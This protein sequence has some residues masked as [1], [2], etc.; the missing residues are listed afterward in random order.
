MRPTIQSLLLG[1]LTICLIWMGSA[2]LYPQQKNSFRLEELVAL[3]LE[4]N[5]Q[6]SAS[7]QNTVAREAAFQ[8]SR[9]LFNPELEFW[10]GQAE[11]YD[12]M[13]ER[14]TF[15]LSVTQPLENPFKRRYRVQMKKEA[16][17]EALHGHAFQVQEVAFRIKFQYFELLLLKE[18]QALL[19]EIERSIRETHQLIAKRAELGEV[20]ELEAIKLYV[21]TLKVQKALTALRSEQELAHEKLNNLV[22]N[23]LPPDYQVSGAL[24]FQT[25]ELDEAALLAR[26]LSLHPLINAKKKQLAQSL[27]NTLYVKWQRLPDLAIRGFSDSELDG[28]NQGVGIALDI[29]LWNFKGRE[30]A[31][32]ESLTH[33]IELEYTALQMD[34]SREVRARLRQVKLAGETIAIFTS[35]LLHQARESLKIADISY[36]EGEISLLDFLDSQRTY[37]SIMGDYHQ[38]LFAWNAELA[39]LEKAIGEPIP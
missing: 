37:N 33:K 16:W 31:E 13:E 7:W 35:G 24:Q 19:G 17:E 20:R 21:E 29:P 23:S 26:A 25:R 36:R 9:R 12:Q 11:S 1:C 10:F 6:V 39:A 5:P 30:L 32:A 4:H 34:V 28:K 14:S 38:A 27:N 18:K 8:A 2:E 15:G 22:G 3:G